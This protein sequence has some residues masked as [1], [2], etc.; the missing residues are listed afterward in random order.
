MKRTDN[1]RDFE[2][3][4][5]LN[6]E[7]K[8]SPVDVQACVKQCWLRRDKIAAM[9]K[10]TECYCTKSEINVV[11]V[12]EEECSRR[13]KGNCYQTCGGDTVLSVYQ[14][15]YVAE[16]PFEIDKNVLLAAKIGC[17]PL[18]NNR[19]ILC[20]ERFAPLTTV[21]MTA[22]MCIF[23]CDSVHKTLFATLSATDS[24]CCSNSVAGARNGM[25]EWCNV[26]CAGSPAIGCVGLM[27]NRPR[28]ATFQL[29]RL[30]AFKRWPKETFTRADWLEPIFPA[31]ETF[32]NVKQKLIRQ[33]EDSSLSGLM[34]RKA[35]RSFSGSDGKYGGMSGQDKREPA[36]EAVENNVAVLDV[37]KNPVKEE[38]DKSIPIIIAA[39]VI[40]FAIFTIA[41]GFYIFSKRKVIAQKNSN[42]NARVRRRRTRPRKQIRHSSHSSY[43][44]HD[45]HAV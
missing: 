35:G 32:T 22:A 16:N 21:R 29:S 18:L 23:Y 14:T 40:G 34:G 11:H 19:Q 8:E 26:P 15:G 7:G 44:Y 33:A 31:G 45:R 4:L 9:E 43:N 10:G 37:A 38:D 12:P 5:T 25:L 17:Y 6:K 3:V 20:N 2:K 1:S 36:H 42:T 30:P 41:F 13:C 39:I 24:C 28:V 27:F